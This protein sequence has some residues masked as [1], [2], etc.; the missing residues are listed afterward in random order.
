[1]RGAVTIAYPMGLPGWDPVCILLDQNNTKPLHE[2][3]EGTF[4]PNE[5]EFWWAGKEMK[6]ETLLSDRIGKNEKTKIKGRMIKKGTGPPMRE[7]LVSER[8]RKAMMA[9]YYKK[10]EEAKKLH[11]NDDDF[12]LSQEWANPNGLKTILTG[13]QNIRLF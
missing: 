6:R 8:E 3:V 4:N 1:M 11:E 12:Y 10:Q 2:V 9:L 13:T 7:P 5:V